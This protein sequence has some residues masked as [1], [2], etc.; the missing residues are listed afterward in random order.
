MLKG[1]GVSLIGG[2]TEEAPPAYK[3]IEEVMQQQQALVKTE[4]KFYPRIVRMHK[5]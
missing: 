1:T 3:N 2:S 5:E 4:G